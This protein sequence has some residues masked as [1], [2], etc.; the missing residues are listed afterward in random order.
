M[1][2]RAELIFQVA[3]EIDLLMPCHDM[4]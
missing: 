1:R 4:P 2:R 3:I